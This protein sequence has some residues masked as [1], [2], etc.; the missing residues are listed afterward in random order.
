MMNCWH[1]RAVSSNCMQRVLSEMVIWITGLSGSGK[2]TIGREVWRRWRALA[3]NTVHVDGDEIRG[4]LGLDGDS[5]YYTL[6]GRRE[7]AHRITNVCRWLDVQR[8]NVVCCTISLFDEIHIRNRQEL[9]EYFEVFIDVPIEVLKQ[10]DKKNLY[11]GSQ[12]NVVGLDL[13]FA[14]PASPHMT[15]DNAA[16]RSELGNFADRICTLAAIA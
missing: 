14:K 9:S 2:S 6:E 15:I 5:Y 1:K 8:I 7:V 10:R 12:I 13:P 4:T 16:D 3:P 11:D